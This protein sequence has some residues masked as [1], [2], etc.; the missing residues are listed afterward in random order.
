MGP[1]LEGGREGWNDGGREEWSS[2]KHMQQ[3]GGR[4]KRMDGGR[5]IRWEFL[6]SSLLLH[7]LV[8]RPF[9]PPSIVPFF[10]PSLPLSPLPFLPPSLCSLS[11]YPL[12]PYSPLH[13][14][15]SIFMGPYALIRSHG[16]MDSFRTITTGLLKT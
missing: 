14:I 16:I 2:N 5:G 15:K 9:F 1:G 11:S 10:S 7:L 4:E 8:I 13:P 6:P 12:H 3:E